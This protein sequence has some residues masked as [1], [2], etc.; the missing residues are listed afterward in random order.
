MLSFS[1]LHPD[2]STLYKSLD[3]VNKRDIGH[4]LNTFTNRAALFSTFK[5]KAASH[6]DAELQMSVGIAASLLKKQE[7]ARRAQVLIEPTMAEPVFTIIGH[8]I[9]VYYAYPRKDLIYGRDGV[10]ILGPDVDRFARLST[11]SIRGIFQLLRVYGNLL[12]YGMDENED[13]YWG[14]FFR[15]V[16]E[17]LASAPNY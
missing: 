12:R 16:L 2:T 4:T 7:L 15:P 6:G 10:H 17:K 9:Y 5:V 13:G 11:D 1:R 3:A 14:G 8:Q